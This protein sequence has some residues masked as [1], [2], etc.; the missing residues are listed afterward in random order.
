MTDKL[1]VA[2]DVAV[3]RKGVRN[4]FISERPDQSVGMSGCG[5]V[6]TIESAL[7]D[8]VHYMP[9]GIWTVGGVRLEEVI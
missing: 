1:T 3:E 5:Q 2:L 7:I 4:F 6:G 9:P 8:L